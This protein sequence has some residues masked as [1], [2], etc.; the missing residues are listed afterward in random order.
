MSFIGNGR[1]NHDQNKIKSNSVNQIL[2]RQ[3]YSIQFS[4]VFSL[5]IALI[6][7]VIFAGMSDKSLGGAYRLLAGRSAYKSRSPMKTVKRPV[8]RPK[9]T[10]PA[11]PTAPPARRVRKLVPPRVESEGEDDDTQAYQPTIPA[12]RHLASLRPRQS[13]VPLPVQPSVPKPA[14]EALKTIPEIPRHVSVKKKENVEIKLEPA[15]IVKAE[16]KL[17]AAVVSKQTINDGR[18]RVYRIIS[19][20]TI[21]L[22]PTIPPPANGHG[23]LLPPLFYEPLKLLSGGIRLG[24]FSN[25]LVEVLNWFICV[26]SGSN[27][28]LEKRGVNRSILHSFKCD[29]DF[30]SASQVVIVRFARSAG[31]APF[32]IPPALDVNPDNLQITC[33]GDV[34]LKVVSS[35]CGSFK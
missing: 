14:P 20:S 12:N 19:S 21:T 5:H 11:D 29:V 24:V 33:N 1:R 16:E 25:F 26:L 7:F 13:S 22:P 6:P 30:P 31:Y 15:R 34:V 3:V 28:T 8:G 9:K 2:F 17:V 35:S 10:Q 23:S 18:Q 27:Q 32:L 4:L